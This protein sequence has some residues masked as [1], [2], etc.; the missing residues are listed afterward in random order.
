MGESTYAIAVLG[1]WGFFG[2]PLQH[3]EM[4]GLTAI[5]ISFAIITY[6]LSDLTILYRRHRDKIENNDILDL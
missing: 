3:R 6:L 1:L 2:M 5:L 4:P